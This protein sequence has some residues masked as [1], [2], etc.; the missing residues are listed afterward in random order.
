MV[1]RCPNCT[2][3]M[4]AHDII[5]LSCGYNTLTRE[6]GKTEEDPRLSRLANI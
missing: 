5:C 4:G 2:S 3:E 6:W 1:P